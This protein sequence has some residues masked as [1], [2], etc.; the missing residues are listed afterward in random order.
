LGGSCS[1]V[2]LDLFFGVFNHASVADGGVTAGDE[3]GVTRG[4]ECGVSTGDE[5]GVTTGE[6]CGVTTGDD[7]ECS[8]DGGDTLTVFVFFL[9]I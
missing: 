9:L 1:F 3:C 6:E 8:D 7:N 2:G 4:D 5:C